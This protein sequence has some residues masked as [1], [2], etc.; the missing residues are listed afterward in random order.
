[1]TNFPERSFGLAAE[2]FKNK[3]DLIG[4]QEVAL[5][6]TG[7]ADLNA[8]VDGPRATAVKYDFLQI[9]LS[10][11][12]GDK[13]RYRVAVVKPEF[14]FEAPAD[15]DDN[16]GTGLLGGEIN[17]RLT[18]RDVILVRI[19]KKVKTAKPRTGTYSN[20]FTPTVSGL[21][22]PVTRG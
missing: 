3:P 1:L 5:W 21:S 9:L 10:R 19:G 14:D 13:Q 4:L 11:L 22:I 20:L 8:P 16:P 6:R 12:N 15:Y 17:G 2:I 7:P 18:M